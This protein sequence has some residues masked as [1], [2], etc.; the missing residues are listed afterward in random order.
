MAPNGK[1]YGQSERQEVL[2]GPE[3]FIAF[4]RRIRG[5]FPDMKTKIED[6]FGV[7]DRVVVRWSS[8]MTHHGDDLG[9]P[10]THKEATT[11]GISIIQFKDG[12]LIAGWDCWDQAGLMKQL[13]DSE[14]RLEQA[15]A[16]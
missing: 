9:I 14:P 3:E 5:A 12:K 10:A 6:I 7:D 2:T 4:A 8:T 1:G 13:S 15:G 11:N 16:A